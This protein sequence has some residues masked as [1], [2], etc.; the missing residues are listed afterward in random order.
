[1]QLHQVR[2]LADGAQ[3]AAVLLH[4]IACW[5]SSSSSSSS[6]SR[7]VGTRLSESA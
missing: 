5:R 6:S 3:H 1:M 7:D 4:G 2:S